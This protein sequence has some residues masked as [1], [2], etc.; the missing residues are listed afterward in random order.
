MAARWR[1]CPVYGFI[2]SSRP[3]N[4]QLIRLRRDSSIKAIVIR[5][6]SG[7]GGAAASQEICREVARTAKFKPVVGSMGGVAAS[8]GYYLLS[9]CTKIVASP[10]SLTGSIGVILNI[11]DAHKLMEKLGLSMQTVQAGKLKG[12][13]MIY[14]SLSEG[15][16]ENLQEM[17]DQTHRQFIA[18]VARGRHMKYEQVAAIAHGGIFTGAKAKQLGLVDALGNFEDAVNLAA[19]LGGIKGEAHPGVARG[20]EVLAGQPSARAGAPVPSRT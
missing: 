17:I 2:E 16:K 3:Y 6:E 1:C 9:P 19:R 11:P 4:E 13:G 10:A 14:R 18:D 20:Q 7:G 8:G 5:V 12:M 15:Q